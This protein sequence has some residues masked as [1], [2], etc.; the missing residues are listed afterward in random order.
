VCAWCVRGVCVVLT[1]PFPPRT[2]LATWPTHCSLQEVYCVHVET[3]PCIVAVGA[4]CRARAD[5]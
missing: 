5:P 3:T 2:H 4:L 1:H